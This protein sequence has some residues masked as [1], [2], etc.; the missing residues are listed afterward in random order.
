MK[1]KRFSLSSTANSNYDA[2][3]ETFTSLSLSTTYIALF[4]DLFPNNRVSNVN[5]IS[6][7]VCEQLAGN[8]EKCLQTLEDRFAGLLEGI[9]SK[10]EKSELILYRALVLEKMGRFKDTLLLL[11]EFESQIPDKTLL[12]E[13]KARLLMYCGELDL[14][15]KLYKEL[16]DRNPEHHVYILALLA[17]DRRFQTFWPALSF[18]KDEENTV[19]A[20]SVTEQKTDEEVE[21]TT[22][23]E[24]KTSNP[25]TPSS[26]S[27]SLLR[28]AIAKIDFDRFDPSIPPPSIAG[29]LPPEM[30]STGVPVLGWL[31]QE[32]NP[33]LVKATYKCIGRRVVKQKKPFI[34]P[35]GPVPLQKQKEL[36]ETIGEL[37]DL[38]KS[39]S[40]ERIALFFLDGKLFA[41]KLRKFLEKRLAKGLPSIFRLLKPLYFLGDKH[42]AA[43]GEVLL[44][45]LGRCLRR[46]FHSKL[47]FVQSPRGRAFQ[48]V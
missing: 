20:S 5:V 4:Q 36:L 41:D 10:I 12:R 43:I 23:G 35:T 18:L 24:N 16:Y 40:A 38:R 48:I 29:Q 44:E 17:C 45:L 1:T 21:A 27:S 32:H 22:T 30:H 7:A 25:A 42:W 46:V 39:E 6:Y 3:T 9:S 19:A 26:S 14:A 34:T 15:G 31:Q 2:Q 33:F 28:E 37:Q 8:P 11:D 13:I 47:K